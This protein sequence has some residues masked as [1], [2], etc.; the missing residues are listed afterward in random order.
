MIDL[1]TG[2]ISLL[3]GRAVIRPRMIVD[4][5]LSSAVGKFARRCATLDD[6][7]EVDVA[8]APLELSGMTFYWTLR[9]KPEVLSCVEMMPAAER[10]APTW[11]WFYR[12]LRRVQMPPVL[13]AREA[14]AYQ[15]CWLRDVLGQT[16]E[17]QVYPP[18]GRI[19]SIHDRVRDGSWI[20]IE[21]AP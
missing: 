5:L 17:V 16:N 20:R 1:R 7:F 19:S 14:K 10:P 21:Y 4:Q 3:E 13:L 8:L 15:D 12:L 9:F 18:W 6:R 2:E 11:G